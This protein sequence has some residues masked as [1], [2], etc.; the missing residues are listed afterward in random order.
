[1]TGR[2]ISNILYS[3]TVERLIPVAGKRDVEQIRIALGPLDDRPGL[4]EALANLDPC[5]VT[6]VMTET[7]VMHCIGVHGDWWPQSIYG[8]V[9]LANVE[10]EQ[11]DAMACHG[12]NRCN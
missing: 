12:E 1:M 10:A 6:G 4:A 8:D 5:P 7:E 11:R 9:L 2:F 3:T